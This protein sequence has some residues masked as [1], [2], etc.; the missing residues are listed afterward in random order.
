MGRDTGGYIGMWE[1]KDA[2]RDDV[3]S[4]KENELEE[5]DA[6]RDVKQEIREKRCVERYV[7]K[8]GV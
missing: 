3:E 4:G 5:R 1:T 2:G 6:E 8:G 7:S